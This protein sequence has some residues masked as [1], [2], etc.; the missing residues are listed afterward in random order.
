MT[1]SEINIQI[2]NKK[3]SA[4][5]F[6][7]TIDFLFCQEEKCR[8]LGNIYYDTRTQQLRLYLCP[9]ASNTFCSS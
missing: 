1:G 8:P 7:G 9:Q 6:T 4:D 2:E 3:M 5:Q